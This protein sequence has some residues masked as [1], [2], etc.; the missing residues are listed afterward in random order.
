MDNLEIWLE[1]LHT[2]GEFP[3]V[4]VAINKTDLSE[5]TNLT[6]EAIRDKY[7]SKYPNMFFVS[8][9]TGDGVSEMFASAA[10][11]ALKASQTQEQI[12]A[13][14]VTSPSSTPSNTKPC[15]A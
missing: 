2:A 8:A 14:N 12:N 4:I 3:P 11:E 6:Q 9:R 10:Q 1:R 7:G 5:G 13:V 15:C